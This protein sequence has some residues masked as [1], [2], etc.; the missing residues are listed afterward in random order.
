MF[1][2]CVYCV[3]TAGYDNDYRSEI[4]SRYY[5]SQQTV[6]V[7]A[8]QAEQREREAEELRALER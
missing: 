5:P 6:A 2:A 8:S 3:I 1:S 7:D 4:G